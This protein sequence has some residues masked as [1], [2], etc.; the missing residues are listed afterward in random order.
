MNKH[1]LWAACAVCCWTGC[2]STTPQFDPF[3]PYG[4]QRIPPPAT[5]SIGYGSSYAQPPANA[6]PPPASNPPGGLQ[7]V[8]SLTPDNNHSPPPPAVSGL[9]SNGEENWKSAQRVPADS[10]ALYQPAGPAP[11]AAQ[12]SPLQD[13]PLTGVRRADHLAWAPPFA[14]P[15]GGAPAP[16]PTYS[17]PLPSYP[18][19]AAAAVAA[20]P[21]FGAP[22]ATFHDVRSSYEAPIRPAAVRPASDATSPPAS[23]TGNCQCDAAPPADANA[24]LTPIAQVPTAADFSTGGMPAS[25]PRTAAD[26]SPIDPSRWQTQSMLR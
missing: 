18:A 9:P 23:G 11:R 5:G 15:H 7:P 17:V 12:P 14:R 6:F 25:F 10:N 8:P 21:A 4:P 26:Y 3:A 13:G 16:A 20:V 19:P 1:W 24:R 2:R 22:S